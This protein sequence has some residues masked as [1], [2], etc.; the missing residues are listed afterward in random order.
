[1]ATLNRQYKVE[2][3]LYIDRQLDYYLQTNPKF[4]D[5]I[6]MPYTHIL[7]YEARFFRHLTRYSV[8]RGARN[9]GK[10]DDGIVGSIRFRR[11]TQCLGYEELFNKEA[12]RRV[13]TT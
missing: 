9:M 1:M 6:I 8:H 12:E 11:A 3:S 4:E 13:W 7:Q 5:A 10:L 2:E